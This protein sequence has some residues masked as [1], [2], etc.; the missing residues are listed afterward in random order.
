MRSNNFT[1]TRELDG[2]LDFELRR[3]DVRLT[4]RFTKNDVELIKCFCVDVIF[5]TYP[6][7]HIDLEHPMCDIIFCTAQN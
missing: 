7:P 2:A 5:K 3:Q 4:G 1:K 6:D